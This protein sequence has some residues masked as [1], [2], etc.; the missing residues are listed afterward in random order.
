MPGIICLI[1]AFFCLKV[2]SGKNAPELSLYKTPIDILS[3]PSLMFVLGK[4]V[5]SEVFKMFLVWFWIVYEEGGLECDF[6]EDIQSEF[7]EFMF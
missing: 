5:L 3:S 6:E 7:A 2:C 1:S 4:G